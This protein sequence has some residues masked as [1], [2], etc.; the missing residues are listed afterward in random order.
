MV[1][2]ARLSTPARFALSGRASSGRAI[3]PAKS[4]RNYSTIG[5]S[6]RFCTLAMMNCQAAIA[7]QMTAAAN[8]RGMNKNNIHSISLPANFHH[9]QAYK[10]FALSQKPSQPLIVETNPV[11]GMARHSIML[12]T[13]KI[14]L[15]MRKIR[16][17]GSK[18]TR[19]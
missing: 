5:F 16:V 2:L 3:R 10:P 18:F 12:M 4:T 9:G 7:N 8:N 17:T 13:R 15:I 19:E 14:S 6:F 1:F 11:T